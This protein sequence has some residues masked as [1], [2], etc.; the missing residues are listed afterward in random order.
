VL[1]TDVNLVATI[2][3]QDKDGGLAVEGIDDKTPCVQ[4]P[5]TAATR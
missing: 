5:T 4:L 3:D 1:P 2:T